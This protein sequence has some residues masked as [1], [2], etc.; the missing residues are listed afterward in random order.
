MSCSGLRREEGLVVRSSFGSPDAECW[1][2]GAPRFGLADY[3]VD[4]NASP[5]ASRL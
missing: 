4:R 5:G 2:M 3:F 1:R